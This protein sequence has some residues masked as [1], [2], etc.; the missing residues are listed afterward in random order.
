MAEVKRALSGMVIKADGTVPFDEDHD[1]VLR[2]EIIA[3][4][5]DAGHEFER[6]PGTAHIRL[7]DWQPG[8]DPHDARVKGKRK[9][10][11]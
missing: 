1:P 6:V 3:H 8:D 9:K 11:R 4:L 2:A 10:G 7:K 5:F